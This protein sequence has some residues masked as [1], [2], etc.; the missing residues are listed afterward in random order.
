M[1]I[2]LRIGAKCCKQWLGDPNKNLWHGGNTQTPSVQWRLHK[3]NHKQV[4][5]VNTSG[6]YWDPFIRLMEWKKSLTKTPCSARI[7]LTSSTEGRKLDKL[8]AIISESVHGNASPPPKKDSILFPIFVKNW[9]AISSLIKVSDK[10]ARAQS[11]LLN[12]QNLDCILP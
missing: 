1:L 9:S 3:H 7:G 11:Q 12:L 10:S 8:T 6:N 5:F 4:E 2:N